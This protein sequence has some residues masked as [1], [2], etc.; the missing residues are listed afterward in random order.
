MR[1]LAF[2]LDLWP[3]TLTYNPNLARAGS[4]SIYIPN[5]KVVGQTVQAGEH[6]Q[7]S[8]RT[9]GRYQ[10]HYLPSFADD[11]Y[12]THTGQ[13]SIWKSDCLPFSFCFWVHF[14]QEWFVFQ[15]FQSKPS[16]FLKFFRQ[17]FSQNNKEINK[18]QISGRWVS[19][20]HLFF[21]K[22]KI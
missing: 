16:S 22:E 18:L 6:R 8:G 12:E 9:D 11:K 20:I 3:T 10:V 19:F 4:S 21:K 5:I 7:T 15:H 17:S 1:F 14:P 2:D 13:A